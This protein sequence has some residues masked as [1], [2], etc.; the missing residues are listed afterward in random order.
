MKIK[1]LA[2]VIV[3]AGLAQQTYAPGAVIEIPV[4]LA[5][6]LIGK[7]LAVPEP[8]SYEAAVVAPPERAL[9]VNRRTG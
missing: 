3:Q 9:A 7:G 5:V 2:T 8:P 6:D 1:L 4:D